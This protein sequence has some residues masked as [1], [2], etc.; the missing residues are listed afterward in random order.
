MLIPDNITFHIHC[1]VGDQQTKPRV[2]ESLEGPW[3]ICKTK[4]KAQ[5]LEE[6]MIA[7]LIVELGNKI[8]AQIQ[9]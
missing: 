2:H 4:K 1:Y 9:K 7:Y 3:K 5:A 8:F 6:H